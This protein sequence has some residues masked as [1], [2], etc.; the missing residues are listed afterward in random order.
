MALINCKECYREISS[1]ASNCPNCGY[2]NKKKG[3]FTGCLMIL[4][5]LITA[6]IVF[7]F[8]FDNGKEGG[9]VI[10]DERTYSKSWRLPQGTEYREIGKIIVQN[11]I[12]VCGEYHLKEIAP[13]EYV[14][15][16]SAD[17]I[18]WHYFVVY[19]S[20]GKIYRAN[21]EMESKLIPPR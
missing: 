19:K 13:Y 1:Q 3:K 15:A 21:D 9:N 16:C 6:A 8:I 2:P 12:K 10:T 7:I 20:R 18:N 17:G 5:G 11:G 14:L 4:L